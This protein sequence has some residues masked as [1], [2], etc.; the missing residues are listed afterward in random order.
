MVAVL[1]SAIGDAL[2]AD[3]SIEVLHT[4]QMRGD[5]GVPPVVRENSRCEDLDVPSQGTKQ[6][7]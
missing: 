2:L 3:G 5:K 4:E 6:G 7:V 1:L